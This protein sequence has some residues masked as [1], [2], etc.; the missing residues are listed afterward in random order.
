M[1]RGVNQCV[2]DNHRCPLRFFCAGPFPRRRRAAALAGSFPPRRRHGAARGASDQGQRLFV[3]HQGE[4]GVHLQDG[5][6]H[7]GGDGAEEGLLDDLGLALA[8][9]HHQHLAGLH[10]GAHAHGV[11]LLG[12]QVGVA[13]EEALVG[14]DGALGQV[15]AVGAEREVVGRLVE[16]YVAVGADA[17]QLQVDAAQ[18]V[19][20]LVIG[21]AG[22]LGVGVGA[23]GHMDGVGADVPCSNRFFCMKYQ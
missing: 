15:D 2:F 22:G 19:D 9:G 12:H 5:G 14:L 6:G 11:G 20:D 17:Q 18:I 4:V 13:A 7:L 1:G 21:L 10:D 16:A 3:A 8:V 23:V